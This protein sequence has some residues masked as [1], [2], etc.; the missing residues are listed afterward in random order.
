M[1]LKILKNLF[2]YFLLFTPIS[3]G[4]ISCSGNNKSSSKFKEEITSDFIP[5]ITAVAALG[6]L[7]PSGE[8]RQLAAPISQFGSSPRVVEILVNEGDFVKKGDIL[9]IFENGEKLIADLERNENLI[10]TINEEIILKNDQ[11]QR[12]EQ[13]LSKDVY[14]FVEFSQRKDELLKLQKPVSYTHLRAHET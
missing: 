7:S 10:N 14:S 13:A 3:L 4:V 6:Q 8:I 12:Y 2:I 1:N 9:A 5:P 11:I